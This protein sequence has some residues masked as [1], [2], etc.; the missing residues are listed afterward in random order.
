M[1]DGTYTYLGTQDL[2][3]NPAVIRK[4][5]S[6]IEPYVPKDAFDLLSDGPVRPEDIHT[7]IL[8]HM[9][10][11]HSGDVFRFPNAKIILG[12]GTRACISPGYPK[13]KLSPF[14]GTVLDHPHYVELT[15]SEYVKI[16]I[17]S[18]PSGCPFDTGYDVFGDSSFWIL[19]A[20]GHMPGHQIALVRTGDNEW[21][22]MGGDCCHHR[23][24]LDDESRQISV[25]V[26]PNGQPGFHKHPDDARASITKLQNL[27]HMDEVMVVLAH[28]AKLDGGIPVYPAQV[29]GWRNRGQEIVLRTSILTLD[30]VKTRYH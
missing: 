18:V 9:H 2:E 1:P 5:Y 4:D 15:P 27:H 30:E 10:F 7:I 25:D 11:D 16:P 6:S 23:A 8:S 22:S 3:N 19:D 14:D 13:V 12:H 20:P 29:S 26:G 17:S 24:L 28:D 21:I